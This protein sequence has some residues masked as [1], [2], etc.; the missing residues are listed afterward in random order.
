MENGIF[1]FYVYLPGLNCGHVFTNFFMD[2]AA[3]LDLMLVNSNISEQLST[4]AITVFTISDMF[5]FPNL[6]LKDI[7]RCHQP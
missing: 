1:S 5:S 7:K 3:T 4:P 2:S 6:N